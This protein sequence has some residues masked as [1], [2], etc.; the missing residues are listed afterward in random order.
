MSVFIPKK[1]PQARPRPEATR[2][3][4]PPPRPVATPTPTQRGTPAPSRFEAAT[5]TPVALDACRVPPTKDEAI[6]RAR[7]LLEGEKLDRQSGTSVV[8]EDAPHVNDAQDV[9]GA[10]AEA[11]LTQLGDNT[12]L[13]AEALASL[14]AKD[15]GRYLAVK[16][17][18]LAPSDGK[19]NGDPVAALALQ[20]MLLEGKLP[21][22]RA[23]GSRDTLLGGLAKVTT[24][25]LAEGIDRQQLLAD[26]VQEVAVPEAVAQRNRGTCVP[27]SIEIQLIQR[28]P[29]EYVRLVSGLAT[30]AGEVTTK[31]GDVLK[32]EDGVLAD[33][34]LRS[35]PQKLLAPALME[36]G[37]GLADYNNEEDEHQGGDI[38]GQKGLTA[39]QADVILESLYGRDHAYQT[40]SSDEEKQAGT[41]FVLEELEKGR[42][43]LVGLE[44]GDGGH[45]VLVTG[46][47]TRDGVEYLKV[48]NPW[49]REELIPKD[50][51]Q[52]RLRNVNYD[53]NADFKSVWERLFGG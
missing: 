41:D 14:S 23:M 6:A 25:D 45:K 28:N 20:A 46:T 42:S 1:I 13:E 50:D 3:P 36:L 37:N 52:A 8:V 39:G 16:E 29:A 44:W 9:N 38:D 51:F 53:P 40:T 34:T 19:P 31:G 12:Q 24:Q 17:A 27:T 11:A 21:G 2:A 7:A 30:P 48:V 33:G 43:V 5:P 22:E 32:R 4:P 47:E 35:L 49:G 18:L 10:R 26:L 15:R